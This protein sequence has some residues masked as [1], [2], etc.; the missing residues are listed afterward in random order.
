[1][2]IYNI[3][4]DKK[5]F[6]MW[7]QFSKQGEKY[8]E[9]DC[10]LR[11]QYFDSC[12]KKYNINYYKLLSFLKNDNVDIYNEIIKGTDTPLYETID[13]NKKFIMDKKD[14]D[15][16]I[17]HKTINKWLDH[18]K[19]LAMESHCGSGKT[20]SLEHILRKL[21]P[22]R[23]LWVS[24]R[25]TYTHNMHGK[26]SK[27]FLFDTYL[28][29]KYDSDK[30]ICQIESLKNIV[31]SVKYDLIILD[32]IESILNHMD[33]P[34]IANKNNIFDLLKFIIKNSKKVI[35]L[36]GDFSN[37]SFVFLNHFENDFDILKNT[38]VPKG[39][40]FIFTNNHNIFDKRI[41]NQVKEGLKFCIITMSANE[42]KKI[43]LKYKDFKKTVIHTSKSDD[44]LK[45]QLTNVNEFWGDSDIIIY[46]PAVGAGVDY[47][48]EDVDYIHVILST[49][50]CS[51]RE[52]YQMINRI[53][54]VKNSEIYVYLNNIPYIT[55]AS[56]YTPDNIDYYYG[57]MKKNFENEYEIQLK[58][59]LFYKI[60]KYNEV[61]R[62]NKNSSLFITGLLKIL[63]KK[64][65]TYEFDD[66][67]TMVKKEK[68]SEFIKQ[69]L[70]ETDDINNDEYHDLLNIQKKGEATEEDKLK[71]SKHVKKLKWG[72]K[73]IDKNNVDTIYKN[74]QRLDNAKQILDSFNKKKIIDPDN[75]KPDRIDREQ[76]KK[77]Q[78]FDYVIDFLK[79]LGVKKLLDG[80]KI[81]QIE[82]ENRKE[83]VK[84]KSLL[85]KD[86][87]YSKML[88]EWKKNKKIDTNKGWLGFV[89]SF[90]GNY[91]FKMYVEKKS[92][93]KKKL[94][95]K[96]IF[97]FISPIKEIFNYLI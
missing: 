39:K 7:N 66:S 53:R 41:E 50:S 23:S 63:D 56:L 73:K 77:E 70:I 9:D 2:C 26:F 81:D 69:Q 28:D 90:V 78:R 86:M 72:V 32:E 58:E 97:Y 46:S 17:V 29:G 8:D 6:D 16:H 15:I 76:Y 89:N 1:M 35:C 54:N 12:E 59:T 4:S 34:T 52:L 49:N 87:D 84:K 47:T 40:K 21:K 36:D 57:T 33:S 79:C 48:K 51:Q 10:K 55:N 74:T 18:K 3:C 83:V 45:K 62:L 24:F 96:E 94:V 22:K 20:F 67:K 88:F 91:G 95:I 61:E 14:D 68:I 75:I 65:C 43:E 38:Y 64:G 82:L 37:R 27:E 85:F 60:Q 19:I 11:W 80:D 44:S 93:R 5:G 25:Q 13:I 42:G 71:I 92:V 31:G 30:L